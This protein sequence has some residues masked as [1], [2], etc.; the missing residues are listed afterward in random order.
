MIECDTCIHRTLT[1]RGLA[2]NGA[3][4]GIICSGIA[5]VVWRN[6]RLLAI[7]STCMLFFAGV[8]GLV[9]VITALEG[10]MLE[11]SLLETL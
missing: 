7:Y 9:A 8:I 6:Q 2:V 4:G 5:A 1:L 3:G 11:V 10:P